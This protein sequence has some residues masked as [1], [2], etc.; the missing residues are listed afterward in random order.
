[1]KPKRHSAYQDP[2]CVGSTL[3]EDSTDKEEGAESKDPDG[4]KGITGEFIMHLARA[5]KGAQEEE[6]HCYHCSSLEHF[7]RD[8]PLVKE[9]RMD[10]HLNWMEGMVLKKGAQAPQ[11]KVTTPKAPKDGTPKA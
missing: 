4:I 6:K 8:C 5:V 9:S 7:I 3:E 10:L 2:C 11:G 1:M